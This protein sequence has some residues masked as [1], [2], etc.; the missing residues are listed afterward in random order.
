MRQ[1]NIDVLT[2][3]CKFLQPTDI[4]NFRLVERATSEVANPTYMSSFVSVK[5]F[6]AFSNVGCS[7]PNKTE[8]F[9]F[10]HGP[11]T[12]V[13]QA[14]QSLKI[15]TKNLALVSRSEFFSRSTDEFRTPG[16]HFVNINSRLIH[17]I[18]SK[19]VTK[20]APLPSESTLDENSVIMKLENS[21]ILV[22]KP[23]TTH[24]L[25]IL[26]LFSFKYEIYFATIPKSENLNPSSRNFNGLDD[27]CITLLQ[28]SETV[29]VWQY[30]GK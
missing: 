11:W 28:E 20:S 7:P 3:I 8:S 12:T 1:L 27:E 24:K 23:E 29:S 30:V 26:Y 19:I 25:L 17:V 9:E 5:G 6:I 2:N 22:P 10:Q 4:P 21:I 16:T 14:L 18:P 13:K 15:D